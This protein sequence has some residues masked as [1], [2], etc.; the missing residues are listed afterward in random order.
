[1]AVTVLAHFLDTERELSRA[2]GPDQ[3]L[4]SDGMVNA[5]VTSS[6]SDRRGV[7]HTRRSNRF[8]LPYE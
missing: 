3:F 4:E 6:E 5:E 8:S 7:R 2:G 1:L